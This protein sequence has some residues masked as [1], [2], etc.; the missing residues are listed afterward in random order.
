M[1]A[2][3]NGEPGRPAPTGAS[4]PGSVP[5]ANTVPPRPNL[6]DKGLPPGYPFKPDW[7]VTPRDVKS[8]LDKGERFVFI[9]CRLPNEHQITHIEGTQL[10]PL[11]QL[12]QRIG[13]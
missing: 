7:E 2:K 9:D 3:S 4:R 5:S 11:Q 8:M 12:A 13:E 1:R 10:I 6:D